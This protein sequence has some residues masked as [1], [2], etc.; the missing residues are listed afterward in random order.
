MKLWEEAIITCTSL[1]AS[2]IMSAILV[3][4]IVWVAK[5]ILES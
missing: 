2:L 5:R 3:Y 4:S 1:I